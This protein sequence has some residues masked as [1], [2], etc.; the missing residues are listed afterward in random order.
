MDVYTEK[1]D[2]T[3]VK[4]VKE[5]LLKFLSDYEVYVYTRADKGYE[6]LGM[7]SFMLVI[8][9]PYSNETL[10]IELGG[11]FTVFFSNWHAHYFAFDSEYEQMK[12]DIRGLLN[13]SI[14]ALSVMDSSNKLIVTDLCS[15][16][17]T[18][19]TDK[20]LFLRS[21]IYD[22]DKFETIIK[23]GGSM[24]VVFWNTAESLMFDIIADD[25]FKDEYSTKLMD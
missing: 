20:L 19:M 7:Y 17:F 21:H 1:V 15:A 11:S 14:G 13:G 5:D 16:D 18:K 23:T 3:N 12:K 10:D 24:H 4:S 9:N 8:K 25:K 22:E 6:Y 2:C